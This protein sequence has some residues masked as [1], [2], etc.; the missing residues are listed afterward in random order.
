LGVA[1]LA[2]AAEVLTTSQLPIQVVVAVVVVET[3]AQAA[4]AAQQD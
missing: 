4:L 1:E 2:Q 3:P